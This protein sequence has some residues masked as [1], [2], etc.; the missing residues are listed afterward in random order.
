M[1]DFGRINFSF[2]Q[3]ACTIFEMEYLCGQHYYHELKE[4]I[5]SIDK[6]H[7]KWQYSK[8]LVKA[9]HRHIDQL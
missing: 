1:T 4:T 9:W 8:V 6:V 3:H 2:V 7:S 5:G